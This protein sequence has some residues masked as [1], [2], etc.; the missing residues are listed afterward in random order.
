MLGQNSKTLKEQKLIDKVYFCLKTSLRKLG[1]E[2]EAVAS[3]K[4]LKQDGL[5]PNIVKKLVAR[6]LLFIKEEKAP[7]WEGETVEK[8]QRILLKAS[9]DEM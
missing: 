6:L 8:K 9:G 1:N 4:I 2:K 7:V 5:V 3:L